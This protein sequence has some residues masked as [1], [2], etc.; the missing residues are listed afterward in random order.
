MAFRSRDTHLLYNWAIDIHDPK[1]MYAQMVL[2]TGKNKRV[3]DIGCATGYVA[4]ELIKRGCSVVGV[5]ANAPAAQKAREICDEVLVG[6]IETDAVAEL[7]PGKFDVV[8][9][10]DVLEHL[11][12]PEH[13]LI[14]AKDWLKSEGYLIV[15]VP[16]IAHWTMRLRLL[17]GRFDYRILGLL[18]RAHLRFFTWRSFA[19]ML[20]R[21]GYSIN[22]A[23]GWPL[24]WLPEVP[25]KVL[26]SLYSHTKVGRFVRY[27]ENHLAQKIP[28]LF[29][30]HFV[31]KC[32]PS[33]NRG[34]DNVVPFM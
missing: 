18:D 20:S 3:L 26:R 6:D 14:K 30:L 21:C 32:V 29:A 5:E 9:M 22:K 11:I 7:V 34:L 24:E 15:S 13:I 4:Y 8:L 17:T 27:I 1:S 23:Q 31:T 25:T 33:N 10:G 12:D 16:N 19:A 28:T 2:L